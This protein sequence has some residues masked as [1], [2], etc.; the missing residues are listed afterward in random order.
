MHSDSPATLPTTKE[1][2]VEDR[3]QPHKTRRTILPSLKPRRS[4]LP[5]IASISQY[6]KD[7][8]LPDRAIKL[9]HTD[10]NQTQQEH[11]TA[12]NYVLFDLYVT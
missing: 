7:L 5:S 12:D 11:T 9:R 3:S 6:F 8:L 10:S 2:P 4:I 1:K